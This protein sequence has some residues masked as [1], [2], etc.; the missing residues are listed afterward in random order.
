MGTKSGTKR[1]HAPEYC[2]LPTESRI[3]KVM[4]VPG[5]EI[6]LLARR[7]RDKATITLGEVAKPRI[8]GV[9]GGDDVLDYRGA[10]LSS[11]NYVEN[12]NTQCQDRREGDHRRRKL[13]EI[14]KGGCVPEKVRDETWHCV[15]PALAL[16]LVRVIRHR[17]QGELT[18]C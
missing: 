16:G 9:R 11:R 13:I 17:Q 14:R 12:R 1:D 7:R 10:S 15:T 2:R 3:W 8:R 18:E 5:K 6:C 4:Y